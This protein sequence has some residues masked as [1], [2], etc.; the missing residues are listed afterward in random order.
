MTI[1]ER[2][3]VLEG[4]MDVLQ[5]EITDIYEDVDFLFDEQVLQDERLLELEDE[6]ESKNRFNPITTQAMLNSF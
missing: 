5:D 2:V 6:T 1:E 3:S 4:Q